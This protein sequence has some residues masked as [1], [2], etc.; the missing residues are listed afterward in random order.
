MPWKKTGI[1]AT[2]AEFADLRKLAEEAARMPVIA[3]SSAD[4]QAGTDMS[5]MAWRLAQERCHKLALGHGLPEIG[6]FYGID[7]DG[8][9]VVELFGSFG[10]QKTKDLRVV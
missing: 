1:K 8:E 7:Q 5:S 10:N 3:L 4:V 9:F 2:E 6:G